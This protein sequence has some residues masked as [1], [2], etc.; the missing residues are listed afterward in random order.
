MTHYNPLDNQSN[1][2]LQTL[3]SYPSLNTPLFWPGI[4]F[5]IYLV[6]ASLTFF[7]EAQREGKANLLSSLAVAGYVTVALSGILSLLQLIEISIVI[8]ILV[9]SLVFQA[10]FLLTKSK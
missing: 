4:L 7:R 8:T 3:L 1:I 5:V 2:D 9:I 10:L 6:I